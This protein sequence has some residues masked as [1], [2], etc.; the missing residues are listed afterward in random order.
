MEK[1]ASEPEMEA[2][3]TEV[4]EEKKRSRNAETL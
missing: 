1:N 4:L 2:S 3:R